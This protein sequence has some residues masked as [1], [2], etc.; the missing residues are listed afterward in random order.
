MIPY[1]VWVWETI[2]SSSSTRYLNLGH[3]IDTQWYL[4][5]LLL[6]VRVDQWYLATLLLKVRVDQ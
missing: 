6:K 1:K 2:P 3:L 4:A 5:T